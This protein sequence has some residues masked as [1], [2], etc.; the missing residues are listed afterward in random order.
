MEASYYTRTFAGL[1][2]RMIQFGKKSK[3]ERATPYSAQVQAGNIFLVRGP[4]N[5]AF[6]TE[7]VNFPPGSGGKDD[8]VDSGSGGFFVLTEGEGYGQSTVV[9][10]QP[11]EREVGLEMSNRRLML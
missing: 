6:I 10:A 3:I 2:I 4:W 11:Y 8:Q 5:E 7:H 1:N 9:K